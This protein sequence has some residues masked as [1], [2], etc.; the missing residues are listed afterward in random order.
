MKSGEELDAELARLELNKKISQINNIEELQ[1]IKGYLKSKVGIPFC[2]NLLRIALNIKETSCASVLVAFYHVQFDQKMMIRAIKTNQMQFIYCTYAFNKNYLRVEESD[3][4]EIS[5]D[6]DYESSEDENGDPKPVIQKAKYQTY[7]FDRL[8]KLILQ[9]CP[10][11]FL[12]KIRAIT[13]FGIFTSENFIM[14]LLKRLKIFQVENVFH[15]C[16]EL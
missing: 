12:P 3:P 7:T 9:F 16:L 5:E 6:S 14:S 1:D 15:P 4:A 2:T 11:S 8:F 10:D 13:N